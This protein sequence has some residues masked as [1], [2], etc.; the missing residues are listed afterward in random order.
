MAANFAIWNNSLK[1]FGLGMMA[2]D[3][4]CPLCLKTEIE[5][6]CTDPEC[7][8][9]TGSDWIRFAADDQLNFARERGLV[10]AAN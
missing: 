10:P 9:Q 7:N 4:P 6:K 3:A 5:S 2:E 8:K 1:T